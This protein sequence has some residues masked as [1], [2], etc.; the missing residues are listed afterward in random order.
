MTSYEHKVGEVIRVEW[1][2]ETGDVRV[3]L[4]IS[5]P[6]FKLRVLHNKD[7]EDIL[8]IKGKDAI[9]VASKNE[10]NNKEK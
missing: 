1:D 2:Q 6:A 9:I 4:D 3:V 7:F 8:T 5:D 10:T